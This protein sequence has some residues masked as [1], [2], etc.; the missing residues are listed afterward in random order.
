MFHLLLSAQLVLTPTGPVA[1]VSDLTDW[2]QAPGGG[3]R[4]D[5]ALFLS[6][7]RL[8]SVATQDADLEPA[9]Y[10]PHLFQSGSN[11]AGTV[12]VPLRGDGVFRIR[13]VAVPALTT[14]QAGTT[15]PVTGLATG[16]MYYNLTS[17]QFSF[18]GPAFSNTPTSWAD[19]LQAALTDNGDGTIDTLNLLEK[20]GDTYCLGSSE[21]SA[22]LA[23]LNLAYLEAGTRTRAVLLQEYINAD[24]LISGAG[25]QFNAGFY[26]DAATSLTAARRLLG[27]CL[28]DFAQS[29]PALL[30]SNG[31]SR[32]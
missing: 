27:A 20:A 28:P 12:D 6:A 14:L 5:W 10:E 16:R 23:H 13:A 3:V 15:F 8:G 31:C 9:S 29:L 17:Q 7:T 26:A 11:L 19:V 21:L 24:L 1:R 18:K 30:Q 2:T 22:A 4:N 25:H 32:N